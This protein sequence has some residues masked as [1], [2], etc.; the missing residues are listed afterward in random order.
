MP[1]MV[2]AGAE[3]RECLLPHTNPWSVLLAEPV[4]AC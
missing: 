3:A 1:T 2:R 4:L